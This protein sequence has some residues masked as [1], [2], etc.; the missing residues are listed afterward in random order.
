M[1]AVNKETKDAKQ[2]ELITQRL[3]MSLGRKDWRKARDE[4]GIDQEDMSGAD[5]YV[6]LAYAKDKTQ[7]LNV[8]DETPQG[9]LLGAIYGDLSPVAG[10]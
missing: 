4:L 5:M 7:D 8:L 6:M 3:I 1:A 10:L 9:D 2:R